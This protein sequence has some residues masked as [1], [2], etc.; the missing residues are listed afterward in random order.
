M[1]IDKDVQSKL[2]DYC[3][4][5]IGE[6]DNELGVAWFIPR[7]IIKKNNEVNGK[8]ILDCQ[9]THDATSNNI[10][11]LNAGDHVERFDPATPQ[12]SRIWAKLRLR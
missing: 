7:E 2:N 3:V 4:P 8:G 9:R 1:V 12:S 11:V 6:W 10:L 5:P